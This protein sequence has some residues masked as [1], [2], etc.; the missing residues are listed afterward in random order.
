MC[1]A[2]GPPLDDQDGR[3]GGRHRLIAQ[4]DTLPEADLVA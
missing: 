4:G 2:A 1:R 3:A